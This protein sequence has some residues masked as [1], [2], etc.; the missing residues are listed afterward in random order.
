[1]INYDAEK[2]WKL[3]SGSRPLANAEEQIKFIAQ[4][5]E[6]DVWWD[7]INGAY[8]AV[9][10]RPRGAVSIGEDGR[11]N[12]TDFAVLSDGNLAPADN[13]V[14]LDPYHMCLLYQIHEEV[15][16]TLEVEDDED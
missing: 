11:Y 16:H 8:T 12:F 5:G 3:M 6:Y 7:K 10:E 15:G 9:K 13:D 14:M 4:M 2:R 1:M